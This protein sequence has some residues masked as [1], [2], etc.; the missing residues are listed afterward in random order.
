M[1]LDPGGKRAV[2]GLVVTAV[3]LPSPRSAYLPLAMRW[4]VLAVV[5]C[6]AYA[7]AHGLYGV[8]RACGITVPVA[9]LYPV[10]ADGL[11]LVAYATI[12]RLDRKRD[13]A[14]A[15]FVVVLAGGLSATA[16][17]IVGAGMGAPSRE[18]RFWVHFAPAVAV[19]LAIHLRWLVTRA[20]APAVADPVSPQVSAP[21]TAPEPEAEPEAEPVEVPRPRA[22]AAVA[23]RRP[24][25]S[26]PAG[27]KV[28]PSRQPGP[29]V[30]GCDRHDGPVSYDTRNRCAD[31]LAAT[32]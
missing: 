6:G 31:R 3:A 10:I 9:V 28:R 32:A 20:T 8:A 7:T 26:A 24:Q 17:G 19:L 23:P 14:Y 12:E 11:A 25:V 2:A 27:R 5:L 1:A 29:C 13:R 16:Q 18:V 22:V 4:A 21:A 30:E 15:W